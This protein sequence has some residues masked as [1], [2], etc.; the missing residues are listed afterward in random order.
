[1]RFWAI[2]LSLW[3]APALLLT[4]VLVRASL[5]KR[6]ARA[7]KESRLPPVSPKRRRRAPAD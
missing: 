4:V 5:S 2:I 7:A 6:A 3:V 1:M